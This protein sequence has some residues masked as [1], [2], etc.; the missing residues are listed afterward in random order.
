MSLLRGNRGRF[1]AAVAE[2]TRVFG[3]QC[4]PSRLSKTVA[5]AAEQ[6]Q[7]SVCQAVFAS[8]QSLSVHQYRKHWHLS[9]VRRYIDGTTCA[10]C[11][12]ECHTRFHIIEHVASK[13]PVCLLNYKLRNLIVPECRVE[14]LDQI[15]RDRVA[16]CQGSAAG[17]R[18]PTVAY[19]SCMPV[20]PVLRPDGVWM[21][22]DPGHPLGPNRRFLLHKS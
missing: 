9:E 16:A 3:R 8:K 5:G 21:P 18:Q 19:R 20:M 14:H 1:R 10:V 7:C 11:N 6:W 12:L 15:E 2:A 4:P 17:R 22:G 13:S